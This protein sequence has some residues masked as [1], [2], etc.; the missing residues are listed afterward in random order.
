MK[1]PAEKPNLLQQFAKNKIEAQNNGKAFGK[2]SD[3]P[4]S[5][6]PH[7]VSSR[8]PA[9]RTGRNGQGKP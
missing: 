7:P 3:S 2:L 1:Q 4:K 9:H 8:P 6:F 5:R